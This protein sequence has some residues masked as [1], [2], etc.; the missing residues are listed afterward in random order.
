MFKSGMFMTT[1]RSLSACALSFLILAFSS[2][3][4]DAQTTILTQHNDIGRTGQNINETILTPSNVNSTQFGKLYAIQLD[5]QSY[6]QPLYMGSLSIGSVTHSVLFVATEN[7]SVYAFD[8]ATTGVPLWKASLLDAAHGATAGAVADPNS[9]TG[10]GN[11]EGGIDGITSTPVIDPSTGTMYVVSRSNE[12]GS[13][14]YRLHA[15]DITTGNEKF[16]GPTVITASV[17][18]TASDGKNGVVTFNPVLQKQAPALLLEAGSIYIG[19]GSF[20]DTSP[21]HGWLMQYSAS[22]LARQ[23]VFLT[24]P[25]GVGSGVW[26]SGAGPA[27]D[28]ENGTPRVFVTTGNGTYDASAPYATN[29]VDYGDDILSLSV[30]NGLKV[31]DAFTPSNQSTLQQEDA[32]LGSGGIMLLPDNLPGSSVAHLAVQVDKVGTLFLL[33]RDNLGGYNGSSDN[34]LQEI[35]TTQYGAGLWGSP[36]YWNGNI[37][38]W[39]A[40]SNAQQFSI[41]NGLLSTSAVATGPDP[42]APSADVFLGT[43]PSVS[44]NGTTNGIVWFNDWANQYGG[45]SQV[46]YAYNATNISTLLW[47]SAQNPVRDSAGPTQK[48]SVPTIADGKVYLA[49]RNQIAVYGLLANQPVSGVSVNLA[50]VANVYAVGS[51]GTV[52][53]NGGL[54]TEGYSYA[55]SYLGSSAVWNST[56]FSFGAANTLSGVSSATIPLPTGNYTA[57][58]LLAT[59]VNGSQTNQVFTV[60][61][62]DGTT[63]S[64]TQ[65]ISDWGG[66]QGY[67]SESTALSTA[68]RVNPSGALQSGPWY[69][70]GYIIPLNS[71]KQVS[72]VT[73]PN[74]RN[75]V[76]LAAS[77]TPVST[78]ATTATPTFSVAAGT[79][80]STQTVSLS[81][82]TSGA[83]IYYTTNGSTPTTS[84][85]VY[86]A[87]ITVS[88]T[89]TISAFA[90][91]SNAANSP[92]ASATYTIQAAPSFTLTPAI[93]PW[94]LQ[95]NAGATQNITVTPVNGFSCPNGVALAVS[96]APS[97]V[98]T[99]FAGNTLIVYPPLATPTGTYPLTLTG[100]CGSTTATAPLSLV[101]TAG[102][103]FTLAPASS[104]INVAPGAN[105]SDAI[106]VNP[107][108]GFSSAVSFSASGFPSGTSGS[109]SPTSSASGTTLTVTTTSAAAAGTY[110]IV[111]TAAAPGSG[112]SN[113]FS[114]SV[115]VNL[116]IAVPK[117][118]GFTLAAA[119]NPL[120]LQQNAGGT[121]N[122][123][124]T[125]VNGFS[126]SVNLAVSGAP[127]GV[128]TGFSGNLLI[129]YPPMSTPTGTYPLTITGTSGSTTATTSVS[130]VITA[131]ATFSLS[132]A[133][134]SLTVPHGSSGTD[135]I[136]VKPAN[137]FTSAV[138]FAASNLPSG[139]TASFSPASSASSSTLTL[140]ASSSAKPGNYTVT[141]TATAPGSGNSNSFTETTTITLVIT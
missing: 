39:P 58:N 81:D 26:M 70:Y 106:T 52:P 2:L 54:D 65:S 138:S 130:L 84:S 40:G 67:P 20:C 92:V 76:V 108:N 45:P 104:S 12:S 5:A 10:C 126:G 16:G 11:I 89:T 83:T 80:P 90:T 50:N 41:T 7:D 63:T 112:N 74:N 105:G 25:N 33:N 59:A 132:P 47:S 78:A 135:V 28:N 124:V 136:T 43:T 17:A 72:S 34:V 32:D 51:N 116:V 36:A 64:V 109:F 127:S 66:A 88:A 141:I 133:S 6:A 3:S 35:T 128:G 93:N 30:T 115:T 9:T 123:T 62:A 68:S 18:G 122:I 21:W 69:L 29:T 111:I 129:V 1:F 121:D 117:T 53:T 102:A 82:A 24:T 113:P 57:L 79:Y 94:S 13:V 85:S 19:F 8:A 131:A 15:L 22:T 55:S 118:P 120:T 100:T 95:Q 91:S 103:N 140:A 114:N 107:S 87:P 96:G 61:Y 31:G 60:T 137:G 99:G 125:P 98:G 101:I 97:G 56:N 49:N 73:T 75:V 37:Y 42:G 134:T 27:A 86:S 48:F 23:S 14:V 4:V 71:A 46:L 38:F 119:A 139:V 110:P 77:L 44:A